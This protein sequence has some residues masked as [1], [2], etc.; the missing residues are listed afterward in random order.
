[1]SLKEKTMFLGLGCYGGKQAKE[2]IAGYNYKGSAAN[3]SEQDLKALGNIPK[4]QLLGFDGFGGHRE[5]ALECLSQ[6]FEFLDFVGNI[7]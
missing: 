5:R 3:G 4:Y 6:N 1:M 2:F 7:K